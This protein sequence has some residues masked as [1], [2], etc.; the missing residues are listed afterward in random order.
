MDNNEKI[1]AR[2]VGRI[3]K[4]ITLFDEKILLDLND[5]KVALKVSAIAART[6]GPRASTCP[7]RCHQR[8]RNGR[9]STTTVEVTT[10][11]PSRGIITSRSTTTSTQS[12]RSQATST[13]S[14]ARRTM[15]IT[16]AGSRCR[17]EATVSSPSSP[18][19]VSALFPV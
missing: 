16:A 11:S 18:A 13:L 6:R 5:G 12:Q 10:T 2:L 15:A 1:E 19:E 14:S 17:R 8:L 3:L 4:A 7:R 9:T